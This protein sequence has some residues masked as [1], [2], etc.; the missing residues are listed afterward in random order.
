MKILL[1]LLVALALPP[2][3]AAPAASPAQGAPS[4][5]AEGAPD[6]SVSLT[7][8]ATALAL[9]LDYRQVGPDLS[10]FREPPGATAAEVNKL[11]VM[12]HLALGSSLSSDVWFTVGERALKPGRHPLGF[13]LGDD[14]AMHLFLVE[15][16]EAFPIAG[17]MLVPGFES[18]RLLMQL[19]FVSR[20]EARLDWHWKKAAGSIALRLGT[21]EAAAAPAPVPAPAPAAP[22]GH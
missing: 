17:E 3:P 13:T 4:A 2:A 5:A 15:G 18:P 19:R 11:R 14:E 8:P 16:N 6:C 9:H 10:K 20:G 7:L 21:P 12:T 22:N 1:V